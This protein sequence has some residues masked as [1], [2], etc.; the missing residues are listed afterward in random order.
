[1]S[2]VLRPGELLGIAKVNRGN[3]TFCRTIFLSGLQ[4]TKRDE[5]HL[6]VKLQSAAASAQQ[7]WSVRSETVQR[8]DR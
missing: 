7:N 6:F 8:T 1:M 4:P 2:N 3:S 5:S